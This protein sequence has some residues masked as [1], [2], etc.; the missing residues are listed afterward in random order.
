[1]NYFFTGS[2][3]L[4]TEL[5]EQLYDD[6]DKIVIYSRDE[7]KHHILKDQYPEGPPGPM[8]YRIGDIRDYDRLVTAM[9]D[10]DIVI[11]TAAMKRIET[12]EAEVYECM[13]TNILGSY[14]VARACNATGIL[15]AMLISTDK[16]VDAAGMYGASKRVAEEL[17]IQSNNYGD[18]HFAVCRYGNVKG[19]RGSLNTIWDK[20][21]RNH[22]ALTVTHADMTRWFWTIEEAAAFVLD[23]L[24]HME[25]G[26][27]YVPKMTGYSIMQM[28]KNLS[29]DIVITG[30][31]CGEKLHESMISQTEVQNTYEHPTYYTIYPFSHE[32]QKNIKYSGTKV[33]DD[34][35]SISCSDM[36]SD[37][38]LKNEGREP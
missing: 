8:R 30:L 22:L 29:S 2:G 5:V 21:I 37:L 34:F 32:W 9:H 16:S 11:H 12:C 27:I 18:C 38:C 28:A 6:A 35:R 24:G 7:G 13:H 23:R 26:V 20:Q 14:N 3:T 1:M 31:R 25:R 10:C 33:P 4:A 17:F 15:C 36:V 19:S